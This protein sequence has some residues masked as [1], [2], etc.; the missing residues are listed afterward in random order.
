MLYVTKRKDECLNNKERS[1]AHLTSKHLFVAMNIRLT[2]IEYIKSCCLFIFTQRSWRYILFELL[3]SSTSHLLFFTFLKECFRYWRS[4]FQFFKLC[5]R[6]RGTNTVRFNLILYIMKVLY[7]YSNY[8]V[9]EF[10][11]LYIASDKIKKN[12]TDI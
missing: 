1:R 4:S 8:N 6:V 5:L 11:C 2:L 9:I 10:V 7:I 12:I 3:N